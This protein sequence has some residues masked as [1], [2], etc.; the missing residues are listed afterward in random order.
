MRVITGTA[1]GKRLA[2]LEGME[3][4][5]EKFDIIFLDPPYAESYLEIAL[6]KI[7]EIDILSEGGIIVCESRVDKELP[8]LSAPYRKDRAYRYGKIKVTLYRKD[9]AE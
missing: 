6:L 4:C 9:G 3:T 1:R 5:R 7:S 2:E 8:P